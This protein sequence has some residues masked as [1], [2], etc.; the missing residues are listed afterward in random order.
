MGDDDGAD[1]T[2]GPDVVRSFAAVAQRLHA[3]HPTVSTE[4]IT[5]LL[6]FAFHRTEGATVHTF[7]ALLAE[8]DV[9]AQ[10]R[11]TVVPVPFDLT[12]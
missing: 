1:P 9:R 6:L 8:R 5:G 11:Q 3:E 10:L 12:A 7:R 2:R 4:S